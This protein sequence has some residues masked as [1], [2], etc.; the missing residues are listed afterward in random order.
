VSAPVCQ[1]RRGSAT[2]QIAA[3]RRH[4]SLA[5]ESVVDEVLERHLRAVAQH[6]AGTPGIYGPELEEDGGEFFVIVTRGEL[7]IR[8]EISEV[9]F[10]ML[11]LFSEELLFFSHRSLASALR[12]RFPKVFGLRCGGTI[13]RDY[14]TLVQVAAPSGWSLCFRSG[15]YGF[16]AFRLPVKDDARRERVPAAPNAAIPHGE[17]FGPRLAVRDGSFVVLYNRGKIEVRQELSE[18]H[19]SMLSLFS[20][21][22]T[23]Y[24]GS[25]DL[26]EALAEH[27]P[28][29]FKHRTPKA[30]RNDYSKLVS[31]S[32]S[33]GWPLAQV[34]GV[35]GFA[36][37][38]RSTGTS[39]PS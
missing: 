12:R 22:R 34:H 38:L 16:E 26:H 4:V 25:R 39:R 10:C 20:K 15:A 31:A 17:P 8:Q 19:F 11:K 27:D 1:L 6:L 24:R 30:L 36:V 7:R 32:Y 18:V 2:A 13:R 35:Y 9:H 3:L 23:L 33:C 29:V 5:L 21:G 14:S 37:L 28:A